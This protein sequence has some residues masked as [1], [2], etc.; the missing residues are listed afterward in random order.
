MDQ[1][2]LLIQNISKI[3]KLISKSIRLDSFLTSDVEN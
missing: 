1:I 3:I 2:K